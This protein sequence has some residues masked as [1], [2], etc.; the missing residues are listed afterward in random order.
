MNLLIEL[1]LGFGILSALC[2][3]IGKIPVFKKAHE[4]NKAKREQKKLE[5]KQAKKNA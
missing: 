2:T 3:G 1:G 5:K 4:Y